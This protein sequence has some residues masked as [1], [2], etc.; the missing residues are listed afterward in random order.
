MPRILNLEVNSL[1]AEYPV[2]P[3]KRPVWPRPLLVYSRRDVSAVFRPKCLWVARMA[4][5]LALWCGAETM[6]N[7]VILTML[8]GFQDYAS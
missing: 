1:T 4:S 7:S 5:R 2:R 3:G 6:S 8:F